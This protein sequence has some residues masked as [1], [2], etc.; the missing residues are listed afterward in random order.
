MS[1]RDSVSVLFRKHPLNRKEAE[2]L[3]RT[4]HYMKKGDNFFRKFV[5]HAYDSMKSAFNFKEMI[6]FVEEL[7]NTFLT[8]T[9][10]E[11]HVKSEILP[12]IS[13]DMLINLNNEWGFNIVEDYILTNYHEIL[14]YHEDVPEHLL[15]NSIKY[16]ME[17]IKKQ[18]ESTDEWLNKFLD[19]K[20]SKKDTIYYHL[21]KMIKPKLQ[22]KY[23][24]KIEEVFQ[25]KY[26]QIQDCIQVYTEQARSMVKQGSDLM[27]ITCKLDGCETLMRLLSL[28]SPTL[29]YI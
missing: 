28:P 5:N 11:R 15:T 27:D 17:T 13:L 29:A 26:E 20:L 9:D 21:L 12:M 23:Q 3:I 24:D 19:K 25:A 7:N 4:A 2:A 18:D 6:E 16:W 10:F 1:L 14:K 8:P 22:R